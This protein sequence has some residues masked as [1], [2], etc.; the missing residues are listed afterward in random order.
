MQYA[1]W[2][3]QL[4]SLYSVRPA[5]SDGRM[6][7]DEMKFQGQSRPLPTGLFDRCKVFR[8]TFGTATNKQRAESRKNAITKHVR[9]AVGRVY[10]QGKAARIMSNAKEKTRS[11]SKDE[12]QTLLSRRLV[13][14][15][16]RLLSL[17]CSAPPAIKCCTR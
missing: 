15:H 16:S 6:T 10:L 2:M 11:P 4:N 17:L 8:N 12:M 7:H 9:I 13:A 5:K 3:M 1:P 14:P